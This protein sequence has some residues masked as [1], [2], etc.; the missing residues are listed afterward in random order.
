M[1]SNSGLIN[2]ILY[3]GLIV[4]DLLKTTSLRYSLG[5]IAMSSLAPVCNV[6]SWTFVFDSLPLNGY[7]VYLAYRFYKDGDSASSRKLFR[8]TLI[9]LPI[10]IVLMMISKKNYDKPCPPVV[11]EGGLE[12]VAATVSSIIVSGIQP[13]QNPVLLEISQT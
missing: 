10:L 1:Q 5:I 6:T 4:P 13:P 7:L 2:S 9:H 8:F 12:A 11:G 3:Y